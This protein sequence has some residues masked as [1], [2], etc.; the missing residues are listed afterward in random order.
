MK[1]VSPKEYRRVKYCKNCKRHR[2]CGFAGELYNIFND[3]ES[4]ERK[5]YKFWV[6]KEKDV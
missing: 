1:T 2:Q 6:K 4:Y 5:W 3:C